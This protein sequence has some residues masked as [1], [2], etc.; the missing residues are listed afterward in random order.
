MN[1]IGFD[2]NT[3]LLIYLIHVDSPKIEMEDKYVAVR[4]RA[5]G[6]GD[7]ARPPIL[8]SSVVLLPLQE[9]YAPMLKETHSI[10]AN[11]Q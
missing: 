9:W 10:P 8:K 6:M 2:K 3:R 11:T 1:P 7:I 5:T 4:D